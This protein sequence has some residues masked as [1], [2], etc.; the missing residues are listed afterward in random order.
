L[1]TLC[2]EANDLPLLVDCLARHTSAY[3]AINDHERVKQLSIE[4]AKLCRT[5]G[6]LNVLAF[7]LRRQSSARLGDLHA[8]LGNARE[9]E[10]ICREIGDDFGLAMTPWRARAAGSRAGRH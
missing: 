9:A 1:A 4:C 2:R 3:L 7:A 5:T 6:N 10:Q 8:A